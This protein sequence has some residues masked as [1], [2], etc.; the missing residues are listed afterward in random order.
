M[1]ESHGKDTGHIFVYGTLKVGGYF[2]KL[3]DRKRLWSQPATIKGTL[4]DVGG[5]PGLSLEGENI[6][7]GELHLYKDFSFVIKHMDFIEGYSANRGYMNPYARQMAEVE[8]STGKHST[9]L[10][11]VNPILIRQFGKV[12]ESGVWPIGENP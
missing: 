7:H 9:L 1:K 4:Y 8:T 11:I 3:F 6:V 2:S 12:I 5:I 10:Y